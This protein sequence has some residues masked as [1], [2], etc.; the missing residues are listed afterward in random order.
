MIAHSKKARWCGAGLALLIGLMVIGWQRA[1]LGKLAVEKR[2]ILP[3]AGEG[4]PLII[5]IHTAAEVRDAGMSGDGS[6]LSMA[7]LL[8]GLPDA[9]LAQILDEPP[10]RDPAIE[11]PFFAQAIRE[12][13]DRD[14]VAALDRVFEMEREMFNGL[15][16]S[17]QLLTEFA[18]N[19][20]EGAQ[21][22]VDRVCAEDA[23]KQERYERCLEQGVRIA[24]MHR[25]PVAAVE[26]SL[27]NWSHTLRSE[28]CAQIV[29]CARPEHWPELA[30]VAQS[31]R[32][33]G[34]GFEQFVLA[35]VA[36]SMYHQIGFDAAWSAAEGIDLDERARLGFDT[37]LVLFDPGPSTPGRMQRLLDSVP[38]E[39]RHAVI[40]AGL[41]RWGRN[42]PVAAA[43]WAAS[44][45]ADAVLSLSWLFGT[46]PPE[47]GVAMANEISDEA[48]REPV[49]QRV[50]EKWMLT[51]PTAAK[52]YLAEQAAEAGQ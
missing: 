22:W 1:Q 39:N 32:D 29:E 19:D 9:E 35:S 13:A 26:K 18:T 25:D 7:R 16:S 45:G 31:A 50:M 42:D 6:R 51:N 28:L 14:P 23:S 36:E 33:H 49:R 48:V 44:Q 24:E 3:R 17:G 47:E 52:A 40:N 11:H 46:L 41:S 30:A 12:F 10:S 43:R 8:E 21:A 2:A 27:P 20:P 4:Q 5:R 15:V 37:H 34:S 38:A